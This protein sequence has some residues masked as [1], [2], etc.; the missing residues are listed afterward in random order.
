MRVR[1]NLNKAKHRMTRYWKFNKSFL[2][3]KDFREQLLLIIHP[4]MAGSVYGN[5]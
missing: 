2:N 3:V 1:I 5:E 4:E